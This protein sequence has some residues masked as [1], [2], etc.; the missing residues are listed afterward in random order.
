MV[1]TAIAS[2]RE[3]R[4]DTA[5][6]VVRI[7]VLS[8]QGAFAA[9]EQLL[10]PLGVTPVQ[11][12]EPADLDGL[13]GLVLPGGESTAMTLLMGSGGLW[14]ALAEFVRRGRP[15]LGTCAGAILLAGDIRDGR[16]DQLSLGAVDVSVRR[17]GFGRQV[18]SFE[19]GLTLSFDGD[20]PFP[21]VFIRAPVI[22]KVGGGVEVLAQVLSPE[23]PTPVLCRQDNVVISTFH[24]EL[25]GDPRVHLLA[26]GALVEPAGYRTAREG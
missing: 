20:R 26:F 25:T 8:V 5:A 14:Q 1:T 19:V 16:P 6:P 12:R 4:N 13:A 18:A 7:G 9:H 17:N 23:G 2:T 11:V 24:P 10:R 22:E 3:N 21:G 15:V